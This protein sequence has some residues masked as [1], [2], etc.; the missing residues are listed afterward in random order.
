[1]C[2]H[3]AVPDVE[4]HEADMN[5]PLPFQDDCLDA[6]VCIEGIEHIK[7]PF[8]FIAECCRILRP[9]GLLIVTTPNISSLRSR[10]RWFLTGFHNKCKYPLD[11]GHPAPRHHINMLSYPQLRYMLHTNGFQIETIATNRIKAVSW[12]YAPWAVVQYVASK[13]VFRR[14]ARDEEHRRCVGEVVSQ[15][16]SAPL[17]FGETMI[18][19]AT[20]R[21]ECV[22]ESG[23]AR[24]CPK[25]SVREMTIR[26]AGGM[27]ADSATSSHIAA[28]YA[29]PRLSVTERTVVQES[30]PS[31]CG[32]AVLRSSQV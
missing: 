16:T 28:K 4:F 7:R 3:A 21:Q 6:V 27:K 8:D 26:K 11:E 29:K 14:C 12:L 30:D 25:D 5:E 17:L 13:L 22:S 15:M 2:K 32:Y 1:M 20:R 9:G 23:R 10:W 24:E 31:G 19:G 18:A